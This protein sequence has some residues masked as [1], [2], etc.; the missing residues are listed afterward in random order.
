MPVQAGFIAQALSQM[1][2]GGGAKH[3]Q[4]A[5]LQLQL[6]LRLRQQAHH[7]LFRSRTFVGQMHQKHKASRGSGQQG[8]HRTA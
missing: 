5:E 2:P 3:L 8:Q 1:A 7:F 6:Q 4:S